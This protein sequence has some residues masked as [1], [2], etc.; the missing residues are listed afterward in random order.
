MLS[1]PYPP[2]R[3]V[4][5]SDKALGA[6]RDRTG[7]VLRKAYRCCRRSCRCHVRK[8]YFLF[9]YQALVTLRIWNDQKALTLRN[10]PEN[11]DSPI[12]TSPILPL[13]QSALD[14]TPPTCFARRASEKTPHS[15]PYGVTL[16]TPNETNMAQAPP[17]GHMYLWTRHPNI[18]V[19]RRK[20]GRGHVWPRN[21]G[22]GSPLASDPG[23]IFRARETHSLCFRSADR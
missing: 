5:T 14:S 18:A 7:V 11:C 22:I 9:G 16:P 3:S 10:M 8:T 15:G 2:W 20:L 19:S 4:G 21:C 1:S 12:Y 17:R 23:S 6:A 13:H